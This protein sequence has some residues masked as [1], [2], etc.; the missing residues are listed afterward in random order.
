MSTPYQ[1]F[2]VPTREEI[3]A[4]ADAEQ[5]LAWHAECCDVAD[6]TRSQLEGR[7]VS[8]TADE[9]WL[10]RAGDKLSIVLYAGRTL[11]RRLEALGCSD[12]VTIDPAGCETVRRQ[13]RLIRDLRDI[14]AEHDIA[15]ET[16]GRN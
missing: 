2:I 4:S 14:L 12:F 5:L 9:E 1:K 11:E 3:A 10:I 6:S 8:E 16:A 13:R 15:D 7:L